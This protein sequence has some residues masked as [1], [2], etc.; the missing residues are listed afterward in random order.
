M[1]NVLYTRHARSRMRQ[2]HISE[3]SVVSALEIPEQLLPSIK[4]RYNA[5]KKV[6]EGTIIR[7]T[8]VEETDHI[9][10]ITVSPRKH[11]QKEA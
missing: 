3:T 2:H 6:T 9:L 7:V 5:L 4:N 11:F 1:K 10:V 8:F